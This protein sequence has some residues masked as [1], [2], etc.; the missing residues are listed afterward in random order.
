MRGEP[1]ESIRR[2]GRWV[3]LKSVMRYTKHH[4]LVE[5]RAAVDK[6]LITQGAC[7]WSSLHRVLHL[8]ATGNSP[9]AVEL[10][11]RR[12]FSASKET[13]CAPRLCTVP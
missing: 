11:I 5:R 12:A 1:L 6:L 10:A 3:S 8:L 13:F 4:V 7:M 2:R 9:V